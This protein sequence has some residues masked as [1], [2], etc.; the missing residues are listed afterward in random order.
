MAFLAGV[1]RTRGTWD[2]ATGTQ[3]AAS[4]LSVLTSRSVDGFW[5]DVD[6]TPTRV[7]PM[8]E[9]LRLLVQAAG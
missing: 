8:V 4:M 2:G 3:L 7:V 6:A 9:A 5:L 1:G